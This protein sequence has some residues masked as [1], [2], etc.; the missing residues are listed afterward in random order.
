MKKIISAIVLM[1]T[2]M[3]VAAHTD[4]HQN[5]YD[6]R[7]GWSVGGTMP[8][9]MP[10]SIRGINAYTPQPNIQLGADVEHR[11]TNHWGY[12]VGIKVEQKDMKTDAQVKT[13]HMNMVKA[14]ESI[15]GYFTGNVVSEARLWQ[16]AV[17][18]MAA[19]R[20][21]EKLKVKAGPYAAL[22]FLKRFEG[23][24]Y[25]GYLRQDTPTG[26]RIDL[27]NTAEERGEYDFRNDIRT[28]H[29][30]MDMGVDYSLT[31]HWGLYAD[32]TLGLNGAFKSSFKT[33]EQTM[34]PIFGTIGVV[35]S[36]K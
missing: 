13:Y 34:H 30:G 29:W 22:A 24:A 10:A 5:I 1:M 12:E 9:G 18:V 6:L 27:G 3:T 23:Y 8:L 32:V 16:V 21:T 19:W 20:P 2:V 31:N 4:K 26:P 28:L 7:L 33:I 11:I 35:Y 14:G 17:P 25:D 15:E 36:I